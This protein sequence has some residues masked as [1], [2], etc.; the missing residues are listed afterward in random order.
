MLT[1]LLI[2]INYALSPQA[3]PVGRHTPEVQE[4]F[5]LLPANGHDL[6]TLTN[7][8]SPQ[9]FGQKQ[10]LQTPR[11]RPHVTPLCC[12]WARLH[13]ALQSAPEV[14]MTRCTT[15]TAALQPLGGLICST[16]CDKPEEP[17]SHYVIM[18]HS[19][20]RSTRTQC[21]TELLLEKYFPFLLTALSP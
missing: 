12:C 14:T 21:F 10:P 15:Y 7:L 16:A 8:P 4:N 6:S 11:C 19:V 1:L 9:H 13:R 20:P 2:Q 18:S 3:S 5:I 17:T